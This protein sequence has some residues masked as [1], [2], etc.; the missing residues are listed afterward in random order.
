MRLSEAVM[1]GAPLLDGGMTNSFY[2]HK[3]GDG[4]CVGCLIGAG[5]AAIGYVERYSVSI[6]LPEQEA[7]R[8]WSWL[9]QI[10]KAQELPCGCTIEGNG[11][12]V[13]THFMKHVKG[14]GSNKVSLEQAVDWIGQI[15][16]PEPAL[17]EADEVN[18]LMEVTT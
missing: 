15:E 9:G 2:F 5:L 1:L 11:F 12:V 4:T 6:I 17:V 18:E 7:E 10:Q 16:P 14:A 3:R 13:L 8:A